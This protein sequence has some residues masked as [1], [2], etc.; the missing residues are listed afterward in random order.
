M[1]ARPTEGSPLRIAL[2]FSTPTFY[3]LRT[4]SY[5]YMNSP[6]ALYDDN[7]NQISDYTEYDIP[8]AGYEYN[9]TTPWRVNIGL[10]LTVD[11]FLAMDAEYEYSNYGSCKVSY[12]G[13]DEWGNA[14][15]FNHDKDVSLNQEAKHFMKGVHT[16]RFGA[17]A[18][19]TKNIYARFGYNTQSAPMKKDAY[20]NLFTNS[21]SYYYSNNTDYV[22]LGRLDRYTCGLGYRG[23]HFYIDAAYQVQKQQGDLYTFHV[24][25]NGSEANRL[26]GAKVDLNRHS[27]LITLGYKF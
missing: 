13:Y 20:L 19:F 4:N 22:N 7:G 1:I 25:E 6:Y 9:I 5:L 17:E 3:N 18:R 26:A 21:P 10:G 24:P 11:K 23:R 16:F 12:G 8:T 2:S 15:L 14:T 27:G